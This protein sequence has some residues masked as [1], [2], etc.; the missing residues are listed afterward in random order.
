MLRLFAALCLGAALC[1]SPA[2]AEEVPAK[3]LFD[4]G[5]LAAQAK[6]WDEARLHFE[7]SLAEADKP[8]TRFNLVLVN[9]QLGRPLGLAHHALAFLAMSQQHEHAAAR[10]RARELLTRA[11]SQLAT[12]T[13]DR[14]P[15]EL[16]LHVDGA[17][18]VASN[19][20]E[21]YLEPGSHHL[22]ATRNGAL[23]SATDVELVAGEVTAWPQPDV[24]TA[25]AEH[26]ADASTTT[27]L[28]HEQVPV[29]ELHI[30]SLPRESAR[31]PVAWTL[32]TMGAALQLSALGVYFGALHRA[33][34][35][36]ERD[37]FQPGVDEARD[38]SLRLQDAVLPIALTGGA[39]MAA[40]IITGRRSIRT[41]SLGWSI[42]ALTLG[43]ALA[44]GGLALAFRE[45]PA[46]PGS[47]LPEPT[48]QA[49]YLLVSSALPL[50]AYGVGFLVAGK[51]DRRRSTRA[52]LRLGVHW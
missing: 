22:Q 30:S 49:G 41:G 51:R 25:A 15:A 4:E 9:E 29:A 8:A 10:A 3:R 21:I 34:E 2:S 24:G 13:T 48:R 44:G 45:P 43:S 6:H 38:D 1:V 26:M 16:E 23:I 42:A 18:P 52:R 50:L 14:L 47:E 5:I 12:L 46:L 39:L 20:S 33:E 11:I 36:S 37:V 27:P 28:P 7:A 32:G 17:K 40:A 19:Q 31:T 35:F